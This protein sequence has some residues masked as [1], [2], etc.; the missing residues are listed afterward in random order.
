MQGLVK[1]ENIGSVVIVVE[2]S[3][4]KWVKYMDIGRKLGCHQR[5]DRSFQIKGYQFPVCARC[6]GVLLGYFFAI[7]L[8]ICIHSNMLI[9]FSIAFCIIMFVDW[10]IQYL[11]IKESNNIRRLFTGILGGIGIFSLFVIIVENIIK[12]II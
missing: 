10:W 2:D 11:N 5:A 12:L 6:T 1:L 8:N 9:Y 3:D 7:L 4:K